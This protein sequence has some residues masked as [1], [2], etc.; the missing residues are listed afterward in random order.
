MGKKGQ[1]YIGGMRWVRNSSYSKEVRVCAFILLYRIVLWGS[2]PPFF[3]TKKGRKP[4]LLPF[5]QTP[6]R[7]PGVE[8]K[9]NDVF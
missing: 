7:L 5:T 9:E 1:V 6:A 8:A 4:L 2:L 3:Y